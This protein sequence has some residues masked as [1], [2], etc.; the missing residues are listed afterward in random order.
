MK[1]FKLLLFSAF[2]FGVVQTMAVPVTYL[3]DDLGTK[4]PNGV[5]TFT[6]DIGSALGTYTATD[7]SGFLPPGFG[8]IG[9]QGIGTWQ[10]VTFTAVAGLPLEL[11]L[12]GLVNGQTMTSILLHDAL[13]GT[14]VQPSSNARLEWESLVAYFHSGTLKIIPVP[15]RGSTAIL[16]L[17]SL[18]LFLLGRVCSLKTTSSRQSAPLK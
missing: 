3:Y 18:P 12:T 7:V 11:T 16:C 2:L 5:A 15:D 10:S 17:I 9:W 4:Y 6:F 14:T 1:C 13:E 8:Y